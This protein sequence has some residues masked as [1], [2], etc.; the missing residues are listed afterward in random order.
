MLYIWTDEQVALLRT[1]WESGLSAT[2][3]AEKLGCTRNHVIGKVHRLGLSSRSSAKSDASSRVAPK[4]TSI[5]SKRSLRQQGVG[6]VTS[7]STHEPYVVMIAGPNGSGK[8]RL[9]QWL[10][11]QG[12]AMGEYINADDI[13]A[14]LVG[15]Y[16][17][18]TKAAQQLADQK[19]LACINEGRSFTFETVMSHD[20]K[21][22]I[23]IRAKAA[24]FFVQLFFIGTDDPMTNIE[25]VALRVSEGGHSVPVDRIIARWH[26][27]MELLGRAIAAADRAFIFDNSSTS[28]F[29]E[30]PP[31]V[32]TW[33]SV[34]EWEIRPSRE[35]SVPRWIEHYVL[36][37]LGIGDGFIAPDY[38]NV[39]DLLVPMSQRLSLLELTEATCH[40]PIGDPSSS[41]FFFCGGRTLTSLP[42]CAHH[43]RMAYNITSDRR[44]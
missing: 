38:D 20:S 44:R 10:Q 36:K 21:I 25:R 14:S 18:R 22:E 6:K 19:R 24:G 23:L 33:R 37:K 41:E 16:E 12:V 28:R 42:Y 31:L 27:S 13:A 32:F 40:W 1:L 30:G 26:R 34:D 35:G 29:G 9:T 43:A 4:K 39:V 15:S 17:S 3:I 5:S 8:T 7:R 2:A 11:S